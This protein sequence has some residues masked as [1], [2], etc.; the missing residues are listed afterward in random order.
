M[1]NM[2]PPVLENIWTV[3]LSQQPMQSPSPI[4]RSMSMNSTVASRFEDM[5]DAMSD[6]LDKLAKWASAQ[7]GH[8][9]VGFVGLVLC[10]FIIIVGV[11]MCCM[12]AA[13]EYARRNRRRRRIALERDNPYNGNRGNRR[14]RLS[15]LKALSTHSE[16]YLSANLIRILGKT[17]NAQ[18]VS[19]TSIRQALNRI[20]KGVSE[21]HAISAGLRMAHGD[22]TGTLGCQRR[23][24][25]SPSRTADIHSTGDVSL[26][27]SW[28]CTPTAPCVD[29]PMSR[30]VGHGK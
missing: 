18:Y 29:S 9:W 11:A 12:Y 3:V 13:D 5:W 4:I 25:P 27:G 22:T 15:Q 21:R 24:I 2:H 1:D 19:K 16:L 17:T 28:A 26:G 14:F 6:D 20:W 8:F 23:V 7:D 30:S 10:L